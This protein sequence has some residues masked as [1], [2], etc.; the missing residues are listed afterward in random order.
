MRCKFTLFVRVALLLVI[1]FSGVQA[2]AVQD[3]RCSRGDVGAHEVDILR[4]SCGS[5]SYFIVRSRGR[6]VQ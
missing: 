1:G 2:V 5:R 6:A 4:R 3:D